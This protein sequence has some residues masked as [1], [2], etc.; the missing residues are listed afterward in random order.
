MKKHKLQK[1]EHILLYLKFTVLSLFLISPNIEENLV[2]FGNDCSKFV[3]KTL[4]RECLPVSQSIYKYVSI[5]KKKHKTLGSCGN[6]K[7]KLY[8]NWLS[9]IWEKGWSPS[10]LGFEKRSR[11]LVKNRVMGGWLIFSWL[12]RAILFF[13]WVPRYF[14]VS[15]VFDHSF[16]EN[17]RALKWYISQ[18]AD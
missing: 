3:S 16:I 8:I 13:K 17:V 6:A 14:P 15:L 7:L 9:G 1:N 5:Q 10:R 4:E 18:K 12:W 2:L 11:Q